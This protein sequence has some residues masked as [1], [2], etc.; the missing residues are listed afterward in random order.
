LQRKAQHASTS[1]VN[2]DLHNF[3]NSTHIPKNV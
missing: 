2:H 3:L 1:I